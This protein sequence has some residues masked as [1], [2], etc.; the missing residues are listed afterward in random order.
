M[1]SGNG[2]ES[3]S[4][5]FL[6]WVRFHGGVRIIFTHICWCVGVCFTKHDW[7]RLC[8]LGRCDNSH[9]CRYECVCSESE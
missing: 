8:A 6:L 9:N 7:S 2:G 3:L 4:G 5:C 1:G